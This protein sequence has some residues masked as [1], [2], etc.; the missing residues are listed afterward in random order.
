VKIFF[1][2][3]LH[4]GHDNVI[5]FDDRPFSDVKEM[6]NELI[7]RW[8]NKVSVSDMVYIL[9]DMFWKGDSKYVQ[10]T[11]KELNGQKYFIKGNHDRW[12]HNSVNKKLLAGLEDY[13]EI[14]VKLEN[15]QERRVVMSHYFI[16]FYNGHFYNGIMLHGH[17]HITHEHYVEENIKKLLNE[18]ESYC[19]SYNVGCMH[20]NYEPVTLDEILSHF[21]KE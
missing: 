1:T 6:N 13:K 10:N 9:G 15:G 21:P 8:N 20:W 14:I 11:L 2:A 17:S 3:D 19:E 4:F 18:N 7:R 16:P 12:L 5:G